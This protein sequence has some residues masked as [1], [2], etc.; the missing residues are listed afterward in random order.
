[1]ISS[2]LLLFFVTVIASSSA[3]T[4][5]PATRPSIAPSTM[6]LHLD[7]SLDPVVLVA[8]G[9]AVV[10][11]LGAVMISQKLNKLD[12]EEGAPVPAVAAPLYTAT[13]T[14]VDVSIPYDAAARLAYNKAGSPGDYIAFKEKYEADAVAAVKA[15]RK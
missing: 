7:L 1:M 10:G 5:V 14:T 9:V 12:T 13:E 4:V 11:G 15:K 6:A 8:G 3:F 2:A